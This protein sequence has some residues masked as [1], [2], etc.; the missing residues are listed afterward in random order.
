MSPTPYQFLAS[1]SHNELRIDVARSRHIILAERSAARLALWGLHRV[2]LFPSRGFILYS[3]A[4]EIALSNGSI[5]AVSW[6]SRI[7]RI[8]GS[9]YTP[10]TC[11]DTAGCCLTGMLVVRG[12]DAGRSAPAAWAAH[13]PDNEAHLAEWASVA[14]A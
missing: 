7:Q 10:R 9:R 8:R 11:T 14:G 2:L 1:L 4:G 6:L 12:S 13:M 5:R 3:V